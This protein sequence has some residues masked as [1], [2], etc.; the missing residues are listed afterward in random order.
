MRTIIAG[1]RNCT[2]L[3]KVYDAVNKCGWMPTVVI[4]GAA[5]GV[6]RLGEIYADNSK[7]LCE[8]YPANWEEHGK[9]AGY[10]RN[11]QMAENAETCIAIWDG[12]SK[13]TKHMIDTAIAKDLRVYVYRLDKE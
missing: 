12:I 13:G 8:R 7:I 11:V 3:Q 2:D 1:S 4:S 10:K 5:R 9:S 6:D